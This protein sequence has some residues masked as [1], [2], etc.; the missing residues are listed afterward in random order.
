MKKPLNLWYKICNLVSERKKIQLE[1]KLNLMLIIRKYSIAIVLFVMFVLFSIFIDGFLN[2]TNM[3]NILRQYSMLGIIACGMTL[4]MIA[5]GFDLSVGS[6]MALTGIIVTIISN[7]F[8]FFTGIVSG[9][10]CGV[11]VGA[12]NGFIVTKVKINAF[13]ATLAS[14]LVFRGLA[15]YISKGYPIYPESPSFTLIG[16]G[17][18]GIVPIPVILF[19]LTIIFF[20]YLVHFTKFG[21]YIYATGGNSE[22]SRL[23]GLNINNIRMLSYIIIGIT[24]AIAGIIMT[25]RVN[26]GKANI[27]EG[28]ALDVIAAVLI[29]G[30]SLAGGAG[31]IWQTIVGVLL[32]GFLTNG[33]NLLNV[34]A[35]IQETIKGLIIIGAVGFD[36]IYS[37]Y[38]LRRRKK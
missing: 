14:S 34:S 30:T 6:N 20:W 19:L 25:S 13:V 36:T 17:S 9:L 7:K 12:F 29:G 3:L 28:M 15:L 16:R 31:T 5:G 23:S 21:R 4:L 11:V 27:A 22:A 26:I 1:K 2:L 18:V 37:N 33:F 32:L 24:A 10:L 38:K 35:F 8:G